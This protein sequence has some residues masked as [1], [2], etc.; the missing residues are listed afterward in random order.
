MHGVFGNRDVVASEIDGQ[1]RP[2]TDK[3]VRAFKWVKMF[4]NERPEKTDMHLAVIIGKDPRTAR[5]Y[6]EGDYEVPGAVIAFFVAEL[7]KRE[8]E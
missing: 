5:R 2:G 6:L 1:F 3:V 8:G 7:L 4:R